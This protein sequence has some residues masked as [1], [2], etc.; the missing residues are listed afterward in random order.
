MNQV[1]FWCR[2]WSGFII[3]FGEPNFLD[4]FL[5]PNCKCIPLRASKSINPIRFFHLPTHHVFHLI[6]K[7]RQLYKIKDYF[8]NS[9][10]LV[11]LYQ[12]YGVGI[13][14]FKGLSFFKTFVQQETLQK[15]HWWIRCSVNIFFRILILLQDCSHEIKTLKLSYTNIIWQDLKQLF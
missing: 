1:T 5:S 2:C 14:N 4:L 9:I 10:I 8:R 7:M 13:W 12:P 6:R 15:Y 3:Y 11:C